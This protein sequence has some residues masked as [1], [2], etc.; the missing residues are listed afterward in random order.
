MLHA[1]E[2]LGM[3]LV[4]GYLA[5]AVLAD[6]RPFRYAIWYLLREIHRCSR[7]QVR[8]WRKCYTKRELKR[9]LIRDE[10]YPN[11]IQPSAKW[12]EVK[13]HWS[14]VIGTFENPYY[15]MKQFISNLIYYMPFLWKDSWWDHS[16]LLYIIE[17]KCRRDAKM[18]RKRGHHEGKDET[19]D[20]IDQVAELCHKLQNEYEYYEDWRYDSHDIKWGPMPNFLSKKP[21]PK[22][23]TP[24]LE[25]Q[26][27]DEF[28]ALIDDAE[29]EK[30]KD[31]VF[32]GFLFMR[33]RNWW[34]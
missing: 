9:M 13:Y 30:K 3:A 25:K 18:Y 11:G 31:C 6:F 15:S 27:H 29:K 7:T 14:K 12:Y 24:E 33:C 10:V 28:R 23:T 8:L 4:T 26:E 2:L 22:A 19:A 5:W 16:Y 32:L 1:L 17:R 21:R 34:D 20:E